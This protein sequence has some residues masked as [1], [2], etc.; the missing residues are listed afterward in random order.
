L[1]ARGRKK[2]PDSETGGIAMINRIAILS[3]VLMIPLLAS[4]QVKLTNGNKAENEWVLKGTCKGSID[5]SDGVQ[6][7]GKELREFV[8]HPPPGL[9]IGNVVGPGFGAIWSTQPIN[10]D[11]VTLVQM[12]DYKGHTM[13]LFSNGDP[14]KPILGLAGKR[15]VIVLCSAKSSRYCVGYP[16]NE[17][18]PLFGPSL[19]ADTIYLAD[20]K[21]RA[22]GSTTYPPC[23]FHFSNEPDGF[24]KIWEPRLST[25]ECDLRIEYTDGHILTVGVWFKVTQPPPAPPSRP[26]LWHTEPTKGVDKSWVIKGTCKAGIAPAS[27]QFL[28]PIY[29]DSAVFKLN[30]DNGR[31]GLTLSFMNGD[32][33]QPFLGFGVHSEG[34]IPID[35]LGPIL[36]A[37]TVYLDG[38]EIPLNNGPNMPSCHFYF[39]PNN[40]SY[41]NGGWENR[42]SLIECV[43]HIQSTD[44]SRVSKEVTFTATQP[45]PSVRPS[46]DPASDAP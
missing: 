17:E 5:E 41:F 38:K 43:M 22:L 37:D 14:T 3:A 40:W 4:A 12:D 9:T 23:K 45:P 31:T 33:P 20:G 46:R 26:L 19:S 1:G 10:C 30:H 29:C 34:I 35:G 44:G 15:P 18:P 36:G 11:S 25:V 8:T 7:Q 28:Q 2:L 21:A 39:T 32:P 42:L 27:S 24:T 16:A 6:I 13:L